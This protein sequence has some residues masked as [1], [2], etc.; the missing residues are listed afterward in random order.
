MCN[1]F[2]EDTCYML[3]DMAVYAYNIDVTIGDN[4]MK[5]ICKIIQAPKT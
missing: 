4:K 1:G 5:C 3:S 2:V